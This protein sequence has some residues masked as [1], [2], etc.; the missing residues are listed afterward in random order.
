M[1]KDPTKDRSPIK[2]EDGYIDDVGRMANPI[3]RFYRHNVP[4]P[5]IGLIE[6]ALQCRRS[7]A[8]PDALFPA[9]KVQP[10]EIDGCAALLSAGGGLPR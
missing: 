4:G 3:G 2:F 1:I 5:D 7:A 6:C 9:R 10:S 8:D